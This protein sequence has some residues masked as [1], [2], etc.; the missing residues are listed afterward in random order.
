MPQPNSPGGRLFQGETVG[1]D[2]EDQEAE[3]E[4]VLEE[5]GHL[6]GPLQDQEEQQDTD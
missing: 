3:T 4:L 5:G 1:I 2:K 6:Q